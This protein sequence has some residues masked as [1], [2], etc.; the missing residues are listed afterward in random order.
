MIKKGA[1]ILVWM[2]LTVS[3]WGCGRVPPLPSETPVS[4]E[5]ET[6]MQVQPETETQI[7]IESD[8]DQEEAPLEEMAA[9][10]AQRDGFSSGDV[11]E[12]LKEAFLETEQ[13]ALVLE[14]S[15]NS[16]MNQTDMNLASKDIYELWDKQLNDIWSVLK[17][18]QDPAF[19]EELTKEQRAW[20]REKEAAVKEA[21]AEYEGG[22]MQPLAMN[23]KAA[24]LTKERAYELMELFQ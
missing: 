22:T 19:M 10:E 18:T 3:V 5:A 7:R 14:E 8:L 23:R 20:I 17:Q 12:N 13:Q 15:L 2:M 6:Q 11:S 24:D 9:Q 1:G 21:G 4:A 16:A